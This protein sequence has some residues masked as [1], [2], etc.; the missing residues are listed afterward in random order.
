[1]S[2]RHYCV[3]CG[4]C[5]LADSGVGKTTVHLLMH[6]DVTECEECNPEAWKAMDDE[7][8]TTTK[9]SYGAMVKM[10]LKKR[11]PFQGRPVGER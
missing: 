8:P 5:M 4:L 7:P 6:H 1:M 10:G 2:G 3:K 11:K 9:L